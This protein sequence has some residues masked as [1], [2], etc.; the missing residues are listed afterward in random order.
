MMLDD[1]LKEC[2]NVSYKE[3]EKH[4]EKYGEPI[5]PKPPAPLYLLTSGPHPT[6]P[7]PHDLLTANKGGVRVEWYLGPDLEIKVDD[8]DKFEKQGK[9]IIE[10]KHDGMW[11]M[12]A[13]GDPAKGKLH[14][15]KS[16]DAKTGTVGGANAGDLVE[17][18]LP[19][20]EGSIL[21][22]ELEAATETS[23]KLFAKYGHRRVHLFDFPKGPGGDHRKLAW[24]GRREMLKLAYAA[25]DDHAKSRFPIVQAYEDKFRERYEA[26]LEAGLEGCVL[27]RK[28]SVYW[29]PRSDGKTDLWHRCKKRVTEDYVLCG[30]G[31]T[32]GGQPA[33]LWG[34]YKGGKLTEV[35]Q[36]QCPEKFLIPANVGKLVAEFMGWQRMDSGALRHAQFVRVRT[37]KTPAMCIHKG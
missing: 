28:D 5:A 10:P 36:K 2:G 4:A 23:T 19:L 20:P 34:L 21:V 22:G 11:V 33:G 30:I 18:P 12:L 6:T 13:V 35:F 31:K 16:R 32:K 25:F 7:V 14:T 27:K 29:T 24:T 1:F 15:L 37:D 8:L 9:W 26:W 17:V 3:L